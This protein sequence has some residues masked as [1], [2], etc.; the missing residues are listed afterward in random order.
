MSASYHLKFWTVI[1]LLSDRKLII[2][3]KS[4]LFRKIDFSDFYEFNVNEP[5]FIDGW[6]FSMEFGSP[7]KNL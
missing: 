4:L 2:S 3:D 6:F 7:T 1:R 5:A